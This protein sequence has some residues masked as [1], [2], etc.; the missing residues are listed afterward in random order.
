MGLFIPE[1]SILN[2][3]YK[4]CDVWYF[5]LKSFIGMGMRQKPNSVRPTAMSLTDL[6]KVWQF[7]C[8]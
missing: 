8:S 1:G 5:D 7:D 2:Q 4:L 6:N 3:Y